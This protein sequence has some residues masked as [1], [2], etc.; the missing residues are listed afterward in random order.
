MK[1]TDEQLRT[2]ADRMFTAAYQPGHGLAP[3]FELDDPYA[4]QMRQHYTRLAAVMWDA[5]APLVQ[6]WTVD[7][8]CRLIKIAAPVARAQ[9]LEAAAKIAEDEEEH[10]VA[11]RIR[12]LIKE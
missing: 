12:A 6:E 7:E 4:P 5:I 1:P 8:V 9:A 2:L 10:H 3:L 11:T